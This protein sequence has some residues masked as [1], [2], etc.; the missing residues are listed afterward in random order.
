VSST[1]RPTSSCSLILGALSTE[2]AAARQGLVVV[3]RM[4]THEALALAMPRGD[5]EFRVAVDR[6]LSQL[7]TSEG[8]PQLYTKWCGAVDAS[9][10]LFFQFVALEE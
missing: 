5:D 4:F 3:D 7:Y 1:E 6:A 9:T 2:D 8:F 10:E